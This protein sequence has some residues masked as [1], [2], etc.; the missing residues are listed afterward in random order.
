MDV[1]GKN[2][3]VVGTKRRRKQG[4][5]R[6]K[7]SNEDKIADGGEF[8]EEVDSKKS[9]ISDL[10][11]GDYW[12][13]FQE[14]ESKEEFV[15]HWSRWDRQGRPLLAKGEATRIITVKAPLGLNWES[16]ISDEHRFTPQMFLNYQKSKTTH[17]GMII[18]LHHVSSKKFVTF[19]SSF[20]RDFYCNQ[21][22]E[23]LKSVDVSFVSLDVGQQEFGQHPTAS[24]IK[25]VMPP[26]VQE[27]SAFCKLVSNFHEKFPEKFVCVHDTSSYN[28]SGFMIVSYLVQEADFALDAALRIFQSSRP[29]GIYYRNFL[30]E[31]YQRYEDCSPEE[32][33]QIVRR[34]KIRPPSWA[35]TADAG[36]IIRSPLVRTSR[37]SP[38]A[39][40]PVSP[41]PLSSPSQVASP[42]KQRSSHHSVALP[43]LSSAVRVKSPHYERILKQLE[44]LCGID[45]IFPSLFASRSV[46][47]EELLEQI[48]GWPSIRSLDYYATWRTEPIGKRVLLLVIREGSF[49]LLPKSTAN[50][51]DQNSS[52]GSRPDYVE[53]L[54]IPSLKLKLRKDPSERIDQTLIEGEY[55]TEKSSSG[56]IARFLVT[57]MAYFQ[58]KSLRRL[59]LKKRLQC[60]QVEI[61]EPL[62]KNQADLGHPGILRFRLKKY[63]SLDQLPTLFEEDIPKLAHKSTGLI[64]IRE[65]NPYPLKRQD[66][67][68]APESPSNSPFSL[69][70]PSEKS[71]WLSLESA[72]QYLSETQ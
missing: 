3:V 51:S 19:S 24:E 28:V 31:L 39:I 58:G 63:V 25:H 9:K 48:G 36:T 7:Q 43:G 44:K 13:L 17:V 67:S 12:G 14:A 60:A 16:F 68:A 1:E 11:D 27:V 37:S 8:T 30:R 40:S 26:T 56:E 5:S 33:Y 41:L 35:A 32:A 72:R 54:H 42:P 10:Q 53:I 71:F 18:H 50:S 6:W 64:L 66:D 45:Q 52:N 46:L 49:L 29:P 62:R 69:E 15:K 55:L 22:I 34:M 47:T 70:I 65:Q 38:S 20:H 23:Y 2:E 57:D 59:S 4:G 21:D 61:L